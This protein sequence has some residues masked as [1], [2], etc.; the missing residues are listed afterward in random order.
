MDKVSRMGCV[1]CRLSFGSYVDGEVQHLTAGGRR[2]GHHATIN[3][4]PWHHRGATTNG[5]SQDYMKQIYGPSF[6]KS[7]KEFEAA[8]GS[9]EQLLEQTNRWL[10]IK[11]PASDV[12][13]ET[14]ETYADLLRRG[15]A[16][17]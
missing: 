2:L 8:F 10:G 6:A 7:R 4:C 17:E 9:E 5:M 14:A 12:D 1:V 3:L 16:A 11:E 13:N 15:F